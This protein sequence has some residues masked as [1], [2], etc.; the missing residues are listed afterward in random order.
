VAGSQKHGAAGDSMSPATAAVVLGTYLRDLRLK[1]ELRLADVVNAGV[2]GS[3]ATLSRIEKAT[4]PARHDVVMDLL[5]HY[6]MADRRTLAKIRG[7]LEISRDSAWWHEFNDV[8]PGWM[9]RLISVEES[10]SDIRTYENQYVPGL[11][12]T[13]EYAR[14]LM[15][16]EHILTQAQR[17]SDQD[18]DRMVKVRTRRQGILYRLHPELYYAALVDEAVLRRPIGGPT[19]F[20]GQ[21]RE[22]FNRIENAKKG[23]NVRIFPDEAWRRV[24]PPGSALTHLQFRP[25]PV[26]KDMTYLET[27]RGGTYVTEPS[28][29]AWYRLSLTDLWT[30]AAPRRESLR[31]LQR[32]IDDL[33]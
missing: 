8:I 6:G 13:P 16:R 28:E 29:V 9:E 21:L 17:R 30:Y 10:A 26:L 15:S 11:L 14:A 31:I 23:V 25:G 2:V 27:P 24:L 4:T 33:A 7:L 19:V 22:L 20:R 12:Q 1:Q 18:I 3:I 32:Y 5:K